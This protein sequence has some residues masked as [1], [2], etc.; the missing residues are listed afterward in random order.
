MKI[1]I[2]ICSSVASTDPNKMYWSPKMSVSKL[3]VGVDKQKIG[4]KAVIK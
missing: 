1:L 2:K 3:S 4:H